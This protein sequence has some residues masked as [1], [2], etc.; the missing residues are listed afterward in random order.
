MNLS[1]LQR[2]VNKQSVSN[3]WYLE[4]VVIVRF[5]DYAYAIILFMDHCFNIPRN[6]GPAPH[7]SS[8][9]TV[10]DISKTI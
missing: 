5:G 1:L 4:L 8:S 10:A 9:I 3:F 7:Q 2:P 6:S